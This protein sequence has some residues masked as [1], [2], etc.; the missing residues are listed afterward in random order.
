[1][2]MKRLLMMMLL[3]MATMGVNAQRIVYFC[4]GD[5]VNVRKGPG[6]NYGVIYGES[7]GAYVQLFKKQG[8]ESDGKIK[9]GFVHVKAYYGPT[10]AQSVWGWVS[11]QYMKKG[12]Q[13]CG[14][15][16]GR[17]YLNTPCDLCKGTGSNCLMCG[18][19]G[20]TTCSQ[21]YKGFLRPF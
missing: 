3:V 2:L 8:A 18:N 4:S 17:G 6:K 15:C 19:T 13:K 16:N 5:N 7:Q 1:M 10:G 14:A 21:C 11:L 12:V 9:N 20:K